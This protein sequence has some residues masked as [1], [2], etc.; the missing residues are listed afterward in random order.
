VRN[1]RGVHS[2][3]LSA[4]ALMTRRNERPDVGCIECR[5]LPGAEH[6]AQ[7]FQE[8]PASRRIFICSAS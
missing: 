8:S 4:A 1:S 3:G 6:Q 2:L 7:S 5:P